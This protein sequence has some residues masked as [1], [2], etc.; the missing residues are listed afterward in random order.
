MEEMI[1]EKTAPIVND[2]DDKLKAI[3]KGF[4]DKGLDYE[5]ILPQLEE[6]VKEGKI[7]A[8]ELEKAKSL[9]ESMS[10]EKLYGMKFVD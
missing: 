10:A 8:D 9:C 2:N 1:K 6:L 4:F 5:E 7:S 3:L